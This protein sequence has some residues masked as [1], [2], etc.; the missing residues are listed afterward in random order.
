[1]PPPQQ[2][3]TLRSVLTAGIK[4]LDTKEAST[5]L[6]SVG[7]GAFGPMQLPSNQLDIIEK[8]GKVDNIIIIMVQSVNF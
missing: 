7:F 2:S 3:S 5:P 8:L 6:D 4:L 1:M